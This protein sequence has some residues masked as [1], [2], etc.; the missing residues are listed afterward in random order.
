MGDTFS[1]SWSPAGYKFY[2]Y[3]CDRSCTPTVQSCARSET[4]S[5]WQPL[6]DEAS[7][8][9]YY[10]NSETEVSQWEVPS[11]A[12]GWQAVY[13]EEHKAHYFWHAPTSHAQWEPP[14]CLADL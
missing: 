10:Y 5:Q 9:Y 2:V 6:W 12:V 11:A 4:Y 3:V 1:T 14:K 7:S 13:A 8:Q